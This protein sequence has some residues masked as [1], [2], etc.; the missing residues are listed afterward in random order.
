MDTKYSPQP[1]Y[2]DE[3]DT[4]KLAEF[5]ELF[6]GLRGLEYSD[7][8]SEEVLRAYVANR[9]LDSPGAGRVGATFRDERAF[10]N[11]LRGHIARWTRSEVSMH[12][13]TCTRCQERVAYL[14]ARRWQLLSSVH[15]QPREEQRLW[16]RFALGALGAVV[17]VAI[18][19]AFWFW[20]ASTPSV[21]RIE[22][23]CWQEVV[24]N[25]PLKGSIIIVYRAP[26]G[27]F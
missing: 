1:P 27:K 12:I 15:Q 26:A 23:P 5:A 16:R 9:L 6:A 21:C 17:A 25:S 24:Q 4:E 14:R 20:P 22:E 8:P 13:L 7:H 3:L 19:A 11:F 10:E 18:L 2:E